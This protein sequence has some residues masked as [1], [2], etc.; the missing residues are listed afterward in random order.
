MKENL[1]IS[2][3]CILWV[4]GGGGVDMVRAGRVGARSRKRGGLSYIKVRKHARTEMLG[5]LISTFLGL[6]YMSMCPNSKCN[7]CI[8][9][10]WLILGDYG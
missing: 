1:S 3:T 2:Y 9:F 5:L 4:G 7:I 6:G 10:F 8:Q